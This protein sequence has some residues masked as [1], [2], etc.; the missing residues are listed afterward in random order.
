[1]HRCIHVQDKDMDGVSVPEINRTKIRHV[2]GNT[3]TYLICAQKG[4][5]GL[6]RGLFPHGQ[7][8]QG[9]RTGQTCHGSSHKTSLFASVLTQICSTVC[10]AYVKPSLVNPHWSPD[11]AFYLN[12]D[13]DP[14]PG[15]RT[16]ATP[17]T[18][19]DPSS[20][21]KSKKWNFYMN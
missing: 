15:S 21:L 9:P 6:S 5:R 11:P 7:L 10:T 12:A 2:Q 18:A 1:M 20:T 4:G 8:W 13:T 19:P 14:D 3:R 17:A 16:N